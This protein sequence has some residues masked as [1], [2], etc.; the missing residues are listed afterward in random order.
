M[1]IRTTVHYGQLCGSS[2]AGQAWRAV[3]AWP[4]VN[5]FVGSYSALMRS[6]QSRLSGDQ[7]VRAVNESS[8]GS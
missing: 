3:S 2:L 4:K 8:G 1:K 5:M 7:A 6:S